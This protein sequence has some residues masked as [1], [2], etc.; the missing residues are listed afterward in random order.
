[1]LIY[2][3]TV[4]MGLKSSHKMVEV[5]SLL[6]VP[7]EQN[8]GV[9]RTTLFSLE[10]SEESSYVVDSHFFPGCQLGTTLTC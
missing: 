3:L 5:G 2:D 4:L 1:M 10:A 6:S 9:G 7:Q 8:R